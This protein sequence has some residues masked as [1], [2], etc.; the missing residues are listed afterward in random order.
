MSDQRQARAGYQAHPP[1]PGSFLGRRLLSRLRHLRAVAVVLGLA[2]LGGA[3]TAQATV[4]VS[5]LGVESVSFF[6]VNQTTYMAQTFTTGG[7]PATPTSIEIRM[8]STAGTTD[9]PALM[10]P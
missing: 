5:N 9:A 6:L 10:T 4:L 7:A 3:G 2:V 1:S 8:Y